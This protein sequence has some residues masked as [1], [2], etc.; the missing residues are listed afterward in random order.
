M[1]EIS[2]IDKVN[3]FI[4]TVYEP[5]D[6][7][8]YKIIGSF[9]SLNINLDSFRKSKFKVKN[10]QDDPNDYWNGMKDWYVRFPSKY[11]KKRDPKFDYLNDIILGLLP[12]NTPIWSCGIFKLSPGGY[13][14]PHTD[15]KYPFEI[16]VPIYW[17]EGSLFGYEGIGKVDM[18]IGQVYA[19]DLS[20][21]HAVSNNSTEDRYVY[22]FIP[23]KQNDA[24]QPDME[25]IRSMIYER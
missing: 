20:I 16:Y 11:Y 12:E 21:I 2:S 17:P 1:S 6:I 18:K 24:T 25:L 15:D 8:P 22:N 7:L 9:D 10:K 19:L 14:V 23:A 3:N 4:N 13:I 5:I